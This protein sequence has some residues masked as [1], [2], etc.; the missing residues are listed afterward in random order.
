MGRISFTLDEQYSQEIE[1]QCIL[2]GITPREY[3][4]WVFTMGKWI[5]SQSENGHVICAMNPEDRRYRE[6]S[7]PLIDKLLTL[8]KETKE[9]L[10]SQNKPK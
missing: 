8:N 6:L 5:L 9:L 7:N 3:T 4:N 2:L 1:E 10:R